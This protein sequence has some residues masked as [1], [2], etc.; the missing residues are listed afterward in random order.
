MP[1]F[2]YKEVCSIGTGLILSG[3]FFVIGL[4]TAQFPYDLPLLFDKNVT[5]QHFDNSLSHYQNLFY[6]PKYIIGIYIGLYSLGMLGCLIRIYKPHP[7]LQ[8][9]EYGTLILYFL[10]VCVFLTNVKT[11]IDSCHYREWGEITENQGLAVIGS[12]NLIILIIISGVLI[13]QI[14]LW[15]TNWDYQS[16]LQEFFAEEEKEAT[17]AAASAGTAETTG[18]STGASSSPTDSKTAKQTKIKTKDS[19]KKQ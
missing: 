12:S 10:T 19:K 13:L 16:R 8:M 4:I 7:D 11:G 18:S 5:Q 3:T 2:T 17:A 1:K 6:T 14:G 9:F 15:W